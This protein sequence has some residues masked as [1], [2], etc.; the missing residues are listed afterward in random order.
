MEPSGCKAS[1][2]SIHNSN[3]PEFVPAIVVA[4]MPRVTLR[5]RVALGNLS[6][7]T[8]FSG[9]SSTTKQHSS[10][11]SNNEVVVTFFGHDSVLYI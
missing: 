6:T 3:V 7:Q 1:I 10:F 8:H 4:L 11:G 2:I 9:I 5:L